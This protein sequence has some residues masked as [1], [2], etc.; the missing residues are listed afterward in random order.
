MTDDLD[1][2]DDREALAT[3]FREHF[4]AA[5]DDERVLTEH[6]LADVALAWFAAARDESGRLLPDPAGGCVCTRYAE[7]RGGGYSETVGEYDPACPV[8]SFHVYDPRA[9]EWVAPRGAAERVYTHRK[10][11]RESHPAWA[12]SPRTV[13]DR[14]RIWWFWKSIP[15]EN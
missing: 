5:D 6:A 4:D 10:P 9:G 13:W 2:L 14:L 11:G 3:E 15:R 1:D 12:R 7:D 8:H